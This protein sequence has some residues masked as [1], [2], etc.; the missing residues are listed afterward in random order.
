[1]PTT[2]YC[3]PF[4]RVTNGSRMSCWCTLLGKYSSRVRPL[5]LNWPVP[6]SRR[7]R[8]MA[9]LRRPT[10]WMGRPS[11][12]VTGSALALGHLLDLEGLGLLRSV[13]VLGAC[14]DLELGEHLPAE[15][16]VRQHPLDGALDDAVGVRA[17]LVADVDR[18]EAARVTGVPVGD[19]VLALGAGQR[20]LARVDDDD[21]VA[22]VDVRGVL[23]LVLAA[24]QDRGLAGESTEHHVGGV[25][26]V[27]GPA[28]LAGLR[29]VRAHGARV[30]RRRRI[31]WWD[32][33]TEHGRRCGTRGHQP[34]RAPPDPN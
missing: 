20:D 19:L 4:S 3:S 6:G 7:T 11:A 8:T 15:A 12:S 17:Q 24:E 23:G 26:D 1:M 16:V 14:V 10:V 21:E 18:L 25:D 30:L 27:P 34:A 32:R 22:D 2:S 9:S 13:G 33:L 5:S 28:D 31:G 29:G